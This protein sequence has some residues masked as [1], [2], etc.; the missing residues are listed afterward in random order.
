M[1]FGQMMHELLAAELLEALQGGRWA[2]QRYRTLQM[3][4]LD[5]HYTIERDTLSCSS[6]AI[7]HTSAGSR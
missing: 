7:S 2:A 4:A 3:G 1:R 5:T 6:P